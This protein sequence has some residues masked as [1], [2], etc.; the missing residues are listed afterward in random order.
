MKKILCLLIVCVILLSTLAG[1]GGNGADMVIN[2]TDTAKRLLAEERLNSDLLKNKGDIFE[3]GVRVMRNLAD[4]AMANLNVP[5]ANGDAVMTNLSSTVNLSTVLT[6]DYIGKLEIDG[7]TFIWSD[8]EENNNSYDYFK[9]LTEN[10]VFS[11]EV[12]A[13]L[14]DNIKKRVRVVDKWVAMGSTHYYLS[15][16][17][18]SE[19]LCEFDTN[20]EFL[21]I[22]KRYKNSDGKDV[23]ELF[24]KQDSYQN[25]MTYIP[26]E[27]YELSSLFGSSGGEGHYFVADNSKGYWETYV[28]GEASEHYNVSYFIMK[29]DI[30]YDAFYNPKD[31]TI[32]LLK[33][34]SA[35]RATDIFHFSDYG[36]TSAVSLQFAGFDGIKNIVAD[37]ENVEYVKGE[38]ANLTSS[39]HG[40]VNLENGKTIRVGDAFGDNVTVNAIYALYGAAG[41]TGEVMLNIHGETRNE[42]LKDLKSFLNEYGMRC[43]RDINEVFSGIDRAYVDIDGIIKYYK[44]NGIIVTDEGR[45]ADAI[46]IELARFADM[47]S[48]YTDIKD[49]EVIDYSDTRKI[50]MNIKF[51]PITES[52]N[53]SI[54]LDGTS[55]SVGSIS[56]TIED[57]T[58]YVVNEPYK[59]AFAMTEANGNG[60]LVHLAVENTSTVSYADEK[61]FTVSASDLS[62][63]LPTLAVGRYILVAYI[64]TSDGIRSSGY[65]P[66]DFDT[67]SEAPVTLD[68]AIFTAKKNADGTIITYGETT[69]FMTS[70]V[71]DTK[72]D[73]ES[74]K[75]L[76]ASMAFEHGTPSEEIEI[77]EGDTFNSLSGAETEIASGTYRIGYTTQNG[78]SLTSGY[79]YA[80]YVCTAE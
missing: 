52:M 28:L 55:V 36:D 12:A 72:L 5:H 13:E 15:V 64:S 69:N 77:K 62:L 60:G 1:C 33:V 45:I 32:P 78:N 14:I 50:E 2:G 29:D 76:I 9:N 65:V 63:E 34:M 38:Y 51:A 27:R 11:A 31:G 18:N 47:E 49:V 6:G 56:L 17:E 59:V 53:E 43:R 3:N 67:V 16:E 75:S 21:N 54:T 57:T 19:T 30:C 39:E 40:V 41:Y 35:D 71:S 58:L 20:N 68:S 22:C 24:R 37:A 70:L 79:I 73:Y 10:I 42:R 25:R 61:K 80:E 4:I 46:E 44:W 8:F 66:V 48:I 23:Y 26:G 74:F 7:D